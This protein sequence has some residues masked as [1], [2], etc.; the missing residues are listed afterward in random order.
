MIFPIF[1]GKASIACLSSLS[2]V[3]ISP[4]MQKMIKNNTTTEINKLEDLIEASTN[5]NP[6]HSCNQ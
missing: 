1:I 2:C 4:T 6:N 5:S 3:N